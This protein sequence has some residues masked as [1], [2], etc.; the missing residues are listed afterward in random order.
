MLT[1]DP[2]RSLLLIV[3]F[4]SRLMPAI[5]EGATAIRNARRLIDMAELMNIPTVFTEQNAKGLGATVAELAVSEARLIHKMTF[6]AVREPEFLEAVAG[7]R[8][9]I[10][11]GCEAHVCVQ[12]T[13]LGLLDAKRK[14]YVVRD[15]LG[16]RR[17]ED[18]ETA[19]RRMERH[20]AEI[21]TTEMVVFEWLE[22]AEHKRFREAI[23][24]IK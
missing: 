17:L 18:K 3:D 11:A 10:V 24:L 19:I 16:S 6:D 15:A 13:V 2:R 23:A 20:G 7:D 1:I 21:V 22:T 4:Q 14:V 8:H 12:Q 5:H 9:V